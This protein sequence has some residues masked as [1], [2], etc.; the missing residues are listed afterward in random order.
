[1]TKLDLSGNHCF[2]QKDKTAVES[3]AAVI[4]GSTTISE[5]NLAGAGIDPD[6]ARILAPAIKAMGSLVSLN[7]AKNKLGVE[8]TKHIAEVLPKW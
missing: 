5:L 6:D 8:G 1:L 3:L 7:L 4:A 2:G